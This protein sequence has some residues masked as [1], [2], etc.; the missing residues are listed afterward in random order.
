[1]PGAILSGIED[2][3]GVLRFSLA[4]SASKASQASSASQASD[5]PFL[6]PSGPIAVDFR[7]MESQVNFR[8][9]NRSQAFIEADESNEICALR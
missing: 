8:Q 6:Q 2:E 9:S 3:K 4:G 7:Y 5:N 1:M